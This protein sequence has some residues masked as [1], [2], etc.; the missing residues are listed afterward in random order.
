[1]LGALFKGCVGEGAADGCRCVE[2]A[3]QQGHSV[4]DDFGLAVV[5]D[6]LV[7]LENRANGFD[8]LARVGPH[9]E[10]S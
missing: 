9:L 3:D 6:A 2:S 5:V 1:M 4:V 8:V 10:E 7:A